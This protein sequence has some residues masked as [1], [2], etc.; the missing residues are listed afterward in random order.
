MQSMLPARLLFSISI[1]FIS[2][3]V[4]AQSTEDS[5][6]KNAFFT[7]KPDRYGIGQLLK[8]GDVYPTS[9][10]RKGRVFGDVTIRYISASKLDSARAFL[11]CKTTVL[12]DGKV[13]ST[14]PAKAGSTNAL[15][16]AQSFSLQDDALTWSITLE[17]TTPNPIR[18]E[19]LS[20]PLLYNSGG[21]ENPKEIFE[22]R[23]VKHHF[24]V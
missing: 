18:I 22:E 24:I 19:D 3:I 8:T 21:G 2:L 16:L 5:L 6:V 12:Q 20:I 7:I 4:T 15:Q 10:I 23:V 9:Y 11:N 1:L 14:W 13:A 17:N